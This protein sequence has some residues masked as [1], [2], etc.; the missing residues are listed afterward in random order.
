MFPKLNSTKISQGSV[1]KLPEMPV[2]F[3][4]NLVLN[5]SITKNVGEMNSLGIV[6]LLSYL[7][8]L[9]IIAQLY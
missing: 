3:D 6:L 2:P 4:V 9:R 8:L 5:P 7:M 1:D